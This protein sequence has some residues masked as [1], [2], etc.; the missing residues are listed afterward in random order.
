MPVFFMTGCATSAYEGHYEQV[1]TSPSSQISNVDYYSTLLDSEDLINSLKDSGYVF[2]GKSKFEAGWE[3]RSKAIK[4]AKNIKSNLVVF[5]YR[6]TGT[7]NKSY[8]IVVPVQNTVNHAG[9]VNSYSPYGYS[10]T[11]NYSGRSTITSYNTYSGSFKVGRYEQE[12]Y[13]FYK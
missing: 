5:K 4:H 13:F 12:A 2:I 6:K 11:H 10:S 9:S 1:E 7:D 3:A 8:N